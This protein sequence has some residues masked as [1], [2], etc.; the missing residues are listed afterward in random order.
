MADHAPACQAL[1]LSEKATYRAVVQRG[2]AITGLNLKVAPPNLADTNVRT[3][4][5][6]GCSSGPN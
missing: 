2:L 1:I 6:S 5:R 4:R 3:A